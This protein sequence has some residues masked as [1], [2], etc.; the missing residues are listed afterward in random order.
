LR[1]F[2][3]SLL[4]K[5]KRGRPAGRWFKLIT[6]A[7]SEWRLEDH[8]LRGAQARPHLNKT[9]Q[10]MVFH[11]CNLICVGDIVRGGAWSEAITVQKGDMLCEKKLEA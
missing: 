2:S 4:K 7:T 10:A 5:K 9:K 1:S 6:L 11:L 3:N 8:C